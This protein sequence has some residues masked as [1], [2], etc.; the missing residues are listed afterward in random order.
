VSALSSCPPTPVPFDDSFESNPDL[1]NQSENIIPSL[2]PI[3]SEYR[4]SNRKFRQLNPLEQK[5]II[6]SSLTVDNTTEGHI[7][8]AYSTE[9]LPNQLP[10]LDLPS[11]TPSIVDDS[12][13]AIVPIHQISQQTVSENFKQM[14]AVI[15]ELMKNS[16]YVCIIIANLFEGIL[17]KG[18]ACILLYVMYFLEKKI[19]F[20]VCTIYYKIF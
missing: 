20:R 18:K 10:T 7:N 6:N 12:T 4:L 2:K 13:S 19:L 15:R 1:K 14:C 3:T 17:I 16:R 11:S 8:H 5:P 9:S